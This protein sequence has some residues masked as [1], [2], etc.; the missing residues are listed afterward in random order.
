MTQHN[1]NQQT[2]LDIIYTIIVLFKNSEECRRNRDQ[3]KYKQQYW[4]MEYIWRNNTEKLREL[5]GLRKHITDTYHNFMQNMDY[6]PPPLKAESFPALY[7]DRIMEA[8]QIPSASMS[9][10]LSSQSVSLQSHNPSTVHVPQL[11]PIQKYY[12]IG[13]PLDNTALYQIAQDTH[14]AMDASRQ[15]FESNFRNDMSRMN[16]FF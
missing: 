15:R 12:A 3:A 6:I 1:N 11:P 7:K 10:T 8:T 13:S 14:S 9:N 16:T 5:E 2:M 4:E